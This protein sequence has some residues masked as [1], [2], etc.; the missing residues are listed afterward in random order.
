MRLGPVDFREIV[1]VDFEF[2]VADGGTPEPRCAVAHEVSSGRT[3][4]LDAEALRRLAAPPW[5]AGPDVL[6]VAF[7]AAA[8]MAC[9]LALGWPMPENILDLY[10]EHRQLWNGM[11]APAGFSLLG[12]LYTF[13]L[14]GI[15][16][17]EKTEM[18]ALALR[19][20]PYTDQERTALLDYCES[21]V[22][23]LG[24]LLTAMAG[25]LDVPRAL[26][27]GRYMR[28]VA[29][30]ECIGVPLDVERLDLL[31]GRWPAVITSLVAEVDKAYGVFEGTSFVAKRFETYLQR[32]GIAWPRHESGAL[33]LQ[34]ET[35][36]LMALAHPALHPLRELRKTMAQTRL[37]ELP[38]GADGRNRTSLWAY[39]TKT[40]RNAPSNAK[41]VFGAAVWLRCLVKPG[42]GRGLAY[43]DYEQQEIGV[44]AALSC[45]SAMASAYESGDPYLAF[46]EQ[47]GLAPAGAT[48]A[49]HATERELCKKL[50]LAL[51][52]GMGVTTLAGHLGQSPAHARELL[53]LHRE[54]YPQFWR[55]SDGA[56]D[57][58][59]LFNSLHS[60]FGWALKGPQR[61]PA[62]RN[63]PM[64]ANGAEM[65]RLACNY[66]LE[67]GVMVCMPVH[68]A[69]LIEASATELPS[70]VAATKAAMA[71]AS[72]DVLGGFQLRTEAA[73]FTF[74]ARFS[75][76]RGIAMWNTVSKLLGVPA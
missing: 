22:V 69:L 12:A 13:G 37:M 57:H 21:D 20:G 15:E 31:R 49:S 58:G 18:R 45:D 33:D 48:K 71:R 10:V 46:A 34:D 74:P 47:A 60:A 70:A 66:A 38:V 29:V 35:F 2:G 6:F 43:I 14:P 76:K 25:K 59:V 67:A 52:Y 44:A 16:E 65:L 28:A 8:E 11:D 4:R 73:T 23:A 3:Y 39:S 19:G 61:I 30:M 27:R 1:K 62:L 9:Y 5:S 53:R 32:H 36:K 54:A 72:A 63:Y 56:V 26:F 51:Q 55:W 64:Q 24:R 7:Y 75:D 41:S 42:P 68:D 50:L 17:V 40:G